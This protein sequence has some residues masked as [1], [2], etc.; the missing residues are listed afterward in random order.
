MSTKL[1]GLSFS[2]SNWSLEVAS[3]LLTWSLQYLYNIFQTQ[4]CILWFTQSLALLITKIWCPDFLATAIRSY[5][6]TSSSL[7]VPQLFTIMGSYCCM[8]LQDIMRKEKDAQCFPYMLYLTNFRWGLPVFLVIQYT[9]IYFYPVLSHVDLLNEI[10]I[11][12]IQQIT[13]L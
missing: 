7:I 10:C 3:N 6:E 11:Y 2:D 13:L 1:Q 9:G 4:C 8:T 5:Q 12:T